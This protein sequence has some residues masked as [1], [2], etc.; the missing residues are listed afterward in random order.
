[1]NSTVDMEM[2]SVKGLGKADTGMCFLSSDL[3]H[4][5]KV[6]HIHAMYR[7]ITDSAFWAYLKLPLL[8]TKQPPHTHTRT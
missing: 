4:T 1:M 5:V 2:C 7:E 8:P 3:L 6:C